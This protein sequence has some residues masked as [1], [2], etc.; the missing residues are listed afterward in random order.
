MLYLRLQSWTNKNSVAVLIIVGPPCH[1][2]CHSTEQ[3]QYM[4]QATYIDGPVF[5]SI[6]TL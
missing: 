6:V 1:A 4:S 5:E 2:D 3:M